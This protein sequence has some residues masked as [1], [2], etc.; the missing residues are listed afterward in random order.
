MSESDK[1]VVY[2][3]CFNYEIDIQDF[4]HIMPL[5]NLVL[6]NLG[7]QWRNMLQRELELLNISLAKYCL[8]LCCEIYFSL[9]SKCIENNYNEFKELFISE[10][11][12]TRIW[13]V[14]NP[15]CNV[16][17][18]LL[19]SFYNLAKDSMVDTVDFQFKILPSIKKQ[20]E[21]QPLVVAEEEVTTFAEKIRHVLRKVSLPLENIIGPD[22][23]AKISGYIKCLS[24]RVIKTQQV[25]SNFVTNIIEIKPNSNSLKVRVIQPAKEFYDKVVDSWASI[26]DRNNSTCFLLDLKQKLGADWNEKLVYPALCFYDIAKEEWVKGKDIGYN[27]FLRRVQ[28]RLFDLWRQSIIEISKNFQEHMITKTIV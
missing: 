8:E 20:P 5:R 1:L 13:T 19:T 12:L 4:D 26:N 21:L 7:E 25:T 14:D 18:E 17:N 24:S 11:L 16:L 9:V 28:H 15:E 10:L 6:Q 23:T 27:Y 2:Y 22:I 3:S